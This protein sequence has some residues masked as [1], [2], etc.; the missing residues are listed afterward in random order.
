[1]STQAWWAI[2]V[3]GWVG[4]IVMV[5]LMFSLSH[6]ADQTAQRLIEERKRAGLGEMDTDG[7]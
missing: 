2:G 1:M 3:L 6:H 7:E 4:F 5:C